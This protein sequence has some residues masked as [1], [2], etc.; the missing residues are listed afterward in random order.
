MSPNRYPSDLTDEEW[1][2]VSK[3]F[4]KSEHR[5][6]QRKHDLRRIIDGCL[7]V[8]RGG[9]SW[10]MMPHDLPPWADVYD[11]FRRW[12]KSGKWEQVN[13]VLRE[14]Y[15]TRRGRKAQPTAAAID[16]QSVKTTE[17]GGPRGYDGGKKV[18]GR[19]RQTLVDTEGDLLKVRVHPADLHDKAGGHC[20]VNLSDARRV[21]AAAHLHPSGHFAGTRLLL[22][23]GEGAGSIGSIFGGRHKVAARVGMLMNGAVGGEKLLGVPG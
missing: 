1:A 2:V 5:G 23:D 11:H 20:H 12:R 15:R 17:A 16:S 9:I 21:G 10:R 14:Q 19:K 22:P 13:A 7:Y 6:A 18:S 8:L 4:T 3:L